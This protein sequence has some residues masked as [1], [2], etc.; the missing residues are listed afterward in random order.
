MTCAN[1]TLIVLQQ[2][3]KPIPLWK[4]QEQILKRWRVRY[5]TTAISARIRD[6]VRDTLKRDGKTV[7]SHRD[8][9]KRVHVYWIG[10]L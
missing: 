8:G 6:E 9:N 3:T 1:Y 2:A 5:E 10:N 7:L 4:I